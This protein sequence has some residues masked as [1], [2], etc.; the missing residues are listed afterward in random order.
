MCVAKST[1]LKYIY[2]YTYISTTI[3]I[4]ERKAH[5]NAVHLFHLNAHLNLFK[6]P[7]EPGTKP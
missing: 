1:R 6:S 3:Q 5:E 7:H 2:T 4:C